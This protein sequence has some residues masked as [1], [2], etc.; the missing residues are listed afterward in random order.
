MDNGN[1]GDACSRGLH[2]RE[3]VACDHVG[4]NELVLGE[5]RNFFF[6]SSGYLIFE[7]DKVKAVC[8]ACLFIGAGLRRC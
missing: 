8:P 4:I 3:V 6:R 7:Q 1:I 2:I 5:T